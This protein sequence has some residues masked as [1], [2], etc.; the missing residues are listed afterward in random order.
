MARKDTVAVSLAKLSRKELSP[1]DLLPY[2]NLAEK[3]VE[4]ALSGPAAG[5]I[6]AVADLSELAGAL[7]RVETSAVNIVVFGGG[8]GLSNIVGGDSRKTDWVQRPFDGLKHVFP[9][10]CSIVCVTDDGGSTGELLKD[11]PIIALGDLRHVLLSSIRKQK[12]Q[13]QYGLADSEVQTVAAVLHALFNFRFSRRPESVEDILAQAQVDLETLPEYLGKSL[14]WLTDVLFSDLRLSAQLGRPHCLGNLL[15]AAAIYQQTGGSEGA[16]DL[17]V[18]PAMLLSGIRYLADLIGAS[19]GAVLPVTTTPA[20]LKV[21]Y[22]N[23]VLIS[24]EYKSSRAQRGSPVDHVFVEFADDPQVPPEVL[25]GIEQA[26]IILFAPGSLFTS[27]VPILQVPG[28]AEAVRRNENALKILIAN[29]WIQKGETDLV[30]EDPGRRFYVSDLIKAYHRNIPAGVKGL[31]TQVMALGL[32]DI[33]GSILQNYAV[34]GKVPIYLDRDAVKTMGFSPVEARIYSQADINKRQVIQHDPVSLARAVQTL[35]AIRAHLPL[36][37][38]HLPEP[39]P[40]RDPLINVDRET[41]DQRRR[42]IRAILAEMDIDQSLRQSLVDIFWQHGDIPAAH[43]AFMAGIRLVDQNDWGRCQTW[44]NVFSFYDPADRMIKIRRDILADSDR[45]E[46][47]FLVALGQS[48]LG[49]YAADKR[50]LPL[51]SAGEAIG[52]VFQ[53]TLRHPDERCCFL[54]PRELHHYLS[55]ARMRRSAHN[56][57]LYTRVV[58]GSEGFTPPGML[59]GLTYAWYLDNRFAAHIEYKMS[60]IRNEISDLV[61]E[62]VKIF[63][64]RRQIINFFRTV[65]F[66]YGWLNGND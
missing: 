49:N 64:R 58:N 8:T 23:G 61:P 55:L 60:I 40:C 38:G 34:E 63:N 20:H 28:I 48:L 27:I 26:D 62:Q 16:D 31:F 19:P 52:Q 2:D 65:V 3:M 18:A 37:D 35:W 59:F 11:L 54:A 24:G 17:S 42:H 66:R 36:R 33:P 43:L 47:A 51:E 7:S 13:R 30:R 53:L 10:L 29:L 4:L 1:L 15:L 14:Y 5:P 41:P 6:Q 22:D 56:D 12:L 44:D 25:A 21:L 39:F 9:K 57:F 50:N 32:Q 45:F 46:V